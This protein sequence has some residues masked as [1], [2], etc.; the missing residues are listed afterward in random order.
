MINDEQLEKS[1]NYIRDT[2]KEFAKAKAQV[3]YL[4]EFRKSKKALLMRDAELGGCKTSA[5]QE[6][7]AYASVDYVEILKGYRD[8]VERCEYLRYMLKGAELKID[9]WR[10]KEASARAEKKAYGA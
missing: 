7:E 3:E 6:R 5:S 8:A 9:V 2:A 1:L 10:S 4:K